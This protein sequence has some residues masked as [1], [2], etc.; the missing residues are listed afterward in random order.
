MEYG[1]LRYRW[2]KER[3]ALLVAAARKASQYFRS[4]I[5]L[6]RTPHKAAQRTAKSPPPPPILCRASSRHP[7]VRSVTNLSRGRFPEG[8]RNAAVPPVCIPFTD[9]FQ[10][11]LTAHRKPGLCV[12]F[13]RPLA[14]FSAI[15]HGI[16]PLQ[17]TFQ[18]HVPSCSCSCKLQEA[19]FSCVQRTGCSACGLGY[20]HGVGPVPEGSRC[21]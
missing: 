4:V 13:C 8:P 7:E 11:L 19:P 6:R 10:R 1:I 18:S 14:L 3:E 15:A 20:P 9:A 12:V 2:H 16:P 17:V 5:C 21:V